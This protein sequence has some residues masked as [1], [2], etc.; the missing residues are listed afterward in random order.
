MQIAKSKLTP[1]WATEIKSM[2]NGKFSETETHIVFDSKDAVGTN[3]HRYYFLVE[4]PEV[5][6]WT[7]DFGSRTFATEFIWL[8]SFQQGAIIFNYQGADVEVEVEFEKFIDTC[9]CV[10]IVNP[11][12][13]FN[14]AMEG[15]ITAKGSLQAIT[16]YALKYGLHEQIEQ[17]ISELKES[18]SCKEAIEAAIDG[19]EMAVAA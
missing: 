7:I 15:G 8:P 4:W 1:N 18:A 6:N 19:I 14:E 12:E 16:F 5:G 10:N 9:E 11:G 2:L 3:M 13:D 17:A